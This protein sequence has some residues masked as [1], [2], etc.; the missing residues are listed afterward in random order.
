MIEDW[1]LCRNGE[2]IAENGL[3]GVGTYGENQ[4]IYEVMFD[5]IDDLTGIELVPVYRNEQPKMEE[6]IL[7]ST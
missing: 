1:Y 4:L 7:L 6:A 3:Q 2:I 5:A